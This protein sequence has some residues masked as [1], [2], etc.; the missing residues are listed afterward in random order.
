MFYDIF[1]VAVVT[2]VVDDH[3]D[4][5]DEVALPFQSLIASGLLDLGLASR[6][7]SSSSEAAKHLRRRRK[8]EL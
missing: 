7:E 8:H 3:D 6:P 1:V 4:D 2:L 5:D